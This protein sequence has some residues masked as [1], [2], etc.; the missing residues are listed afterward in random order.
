ME[1]LEEHHSYILFCK[2]AFWNIDETGCPPEIRDLA[3]KFLQK[4]QG[5]PIAIVCIGRLLSCK[6]PTYTEWENVYKQ[7][8][9]QS[10]KN[11]I[12]GVDSIL[13]ASFEDLPYE[14]KNCFLHCALFPED[15]ELKR[16]RLIRQWIADG[17]IKEK[18]NKTLEQVAQG[19]LEELVNRS[20]LHVVKSNEFGQ[21]KCCRMHDIIRHLAMDK[22]H[23][24]YFGKVYQDHGTF[25]VHGTRR[26]SI[27]STNI[28]PLNL[29]S[30]T[31]LRAIYVIRSSFDIDL[32]RPIL[33]SSILLSTLDLHGTQIKML[34]NEVYNLFNLRYLGLRDTQIQSLP[35]AIGRLQNLVVLDAIGTSLLSLPN[36]VV[37]LSK[38]RYLYATVMINEGLYQWRQRGVKV[39][40]GIRNLTG[41]HVLQIVKA[42]TETLCDVAALI[43]LRTFAVEDVKSEHTVSLRR[44]LLNM[45]NLTFLFIATSNES[46]VL[47][48]ENSV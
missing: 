26:I 13:K 20:L 5:F 31:H 35:A 39:P 47:P 45:T 36:D 41:L 21:V 32:L 28:V 7:L 27:Q 3:M 46:E 19:Y 10:N 18:E 11:A 16:R 1:P 8:E 40:M 43:E 29:S 6:P 25:S 34:P 4:C 23:K 15:Y 24:E 38:L 48:L 42:S 9:M 33:T 17:F 44:A 37:K 14:L 30:A 22:A 12:S 2:V